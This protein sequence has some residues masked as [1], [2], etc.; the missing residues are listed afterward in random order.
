MADTLGVEFVGV[1]SSSMDSGGWKAQVSAYRC[2]LC[3]LREDDG[4]FS[5]VV[6][7]LPGAGSCGDTVEE[8]I[9]NT[10]EA[11]LGVIETYR[12]TGDS[13]PW[14]NSAAEEI[15]EGAELKWILVNA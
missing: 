1:N 4:S 8:A 10:K 5:V 12:E 14:I 9:E 2:H 11:V 13:V 6:L 15:P 3:I 7:N